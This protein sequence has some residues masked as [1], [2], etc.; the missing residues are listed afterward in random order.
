MVKLLLRFNVNV[1]Q[2]GKYCRTALHEAAHLGLTDLVKMLLKS[3]A[4][5]DPRSTYGL[6]PLAL[7]AQGGYFEIVKE[8]IQRG[9]S[10]FE[11]NYTCIK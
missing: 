5:P 4:R 9:W 10:S 8:L 2:L 7:A 3:G 11:T 6:T 1:N